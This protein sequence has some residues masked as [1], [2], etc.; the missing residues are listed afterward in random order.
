M[1]DLLV[2]DLLSLNLPGEKKARRF[3]TFYKYFSANSANERP[4]KN[5]T[6]W[7]RQTENTQ[8]DGHGDSMTELAQRGQFSENELSLLLFIY[9]KI[10][11]T[12][13]GKKKF[14]FI[15][16][17]C[18]VSVLLSK[19]LK[20]IVISRISASQQLVVKSHL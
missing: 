15:F 3:K 2:T 18:F 16:R 9:P 17:V 19:H 12:K 5:C 13:S 8:T 4:R 10:N 14:F 6:R 7:R 20:R 11:S 1:I